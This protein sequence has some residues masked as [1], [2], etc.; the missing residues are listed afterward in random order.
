MLV[1]GEDWDQRVAEKAEAARVEM[2]ELAG[3]IDDVMLDLCDRRSELAEHALGEHNYLD[4]PDLGKALDLRQRWERLNRS[5]ESFHK[6]VAR[7][8]RQLPGNETGK[9]APTEKKPR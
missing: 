2:R 8:V 3:R 7:Q 4:D 9:T 6:A 1:Y 5:L